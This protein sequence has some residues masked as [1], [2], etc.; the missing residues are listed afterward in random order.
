VSKS[1]QIYLGLL[2]GILIGAMLPN[3]QATQY[4]LDTG[5]NANLITILNSHA[6]YLDEIKA[7]FNL[8]RADFVLLKANCE[9]RN[10]G[11]PGLAE[12]T[13]A[14]TLKTAAVTSYTIAGVNY[15][16]A[17]TD[18]LA[19]TACTQ[20]AISTYCL[21]L[22]SINSSGTVTTTK[23]TSTATDTATLP[24]LPA[25]SAAIGYF[26]VVTD[27]SHTFTSGTT[28]LSAAGITATYKDLSIP[29]TGSSA[30]TSTSTT[31][32]AAAAD[33]ARSH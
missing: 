27:A 8:I 25:S 16:K 28:D 7:D 10:F 32:D 1:F 11:V 5:S 17:A 14:N 22:V 33:T 23:G 9:N 2:L 3:V 15:S 24:A 6:T 19:M 20:Q 29:D 4:R 31:V 12:G 18:N 30:D 13:N 26:K 21:Y